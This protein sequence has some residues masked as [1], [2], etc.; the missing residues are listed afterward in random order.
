MLAMLDKIVAAKALG[1][2][3]ANGSAYAAQKI[4]QGAEDWVVAVKNQE[5]PAHMPQVKRSL[6]L[7]YAVNPFGADH[8]SSE[9]DPGYTPES[10]PI[11]LER[12]ARLGLT[13]PQPD[14]VLNREKA[15][16]ALY[17]RVE[18]FVHGQRRPV[19]VRVWPVVAAVWGRDEMVE[20]MRAVT[21]WE[22]TVE[23]H[24]AH[25]RAAAQ[26]DARL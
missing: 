21:G 9:H 15:K 16:L 19:P 11:S 20:L 1:D 4:G 25:R 2:V 22:M 26:P 3:L 14:R 12:M 17:T 5:L 13:D 6:A 8:Q 23:R 7:V 18:L 10:A 24:A